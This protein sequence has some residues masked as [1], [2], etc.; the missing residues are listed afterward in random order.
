LESEIART[1]P[2]FEYSA[3]SLK[4]ESDGSNVGLLMAAGWADWTELE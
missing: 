3:L 2:G 1:V 4:R